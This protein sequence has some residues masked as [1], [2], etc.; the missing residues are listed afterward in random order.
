MLADANKGSDHER[1]HEDEEE[2]A[3]AP[4]RSPGV[5]TSF[6]YAIPPSLAT[7]TSMQHSPLSDVHSPE[8]DDEDLLSSGDELLTRHA[9]AQQLSGLSLEDV[10]LDRR[11]FGKSSTFMMVKKAAD[12]KK[13]HQPESSNSSPEPA[14][15]KAGLTYPSITDARGVSYLRCGCPDYGNFNPVS[16]EACHHDE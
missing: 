10:K 16:I 4:V 5:D 14:L 12:L 2:E 7:H 15:N 6:D 13:Q 9:L 11:F 8:G 3:E 1:D